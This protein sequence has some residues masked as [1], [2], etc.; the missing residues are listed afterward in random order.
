MACVGVLVAG[1]VARADDA[2][3]R[4]AEMTNLMESVAEDGTAS[5]GI[6]PPRLAFLVESV[7]VDPESYAE[8]QG[9]TGHMSPKKTVVALSADKKVAW[10]AS[11]LDE[12]QYCGDDSCFRD[13]PF[14]TLHATMLVELTT[15][16]HPVAIHIAMPM[17]GKAQAKAVE[18]GGAMSALPVEVEDGA[19]DAVE[20]FKQTL[21]DPTAMVAS[22][23]TRKD[24][25]LYG[26]SAGERWVGGAAVKAQLKKW[27]L[28]M[29]LLDGVQAG[30]TTGGGVA[31]VAANVSARAIKRPKDKAM[32][33]RVLFLYEKVGS[34]WQLVQAHF[35]YPVLGQ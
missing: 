26:S 12:Y 17:T 3:A 29:T 25:V 14:G 21:A 20:L 24:V 31:W 9:A 11:D 16:I 33:Y 10:I 28:G 19:T 34:A 30:V 32:P 22:V 1:A 6:K 35:S 5:E 27:G 2:K 15:P 8:P 4:T 18:L 7:L 23:S 13:K